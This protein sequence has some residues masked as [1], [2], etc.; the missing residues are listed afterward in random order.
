MVHE[1]CHPGVQLLHLQSALS[2]TE[3]TCEKEGRRSGSMQ[4]WVLYLGTL[5]FRGN[6]T[7]EA[8]SELSKQGF[9]EHSR[10]NRVPVLRPRTCSEKG[11]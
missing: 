6:K 1:A 10:E 5:K 7:A 3:P 8:S 9:E 2:R 4:T 11:D